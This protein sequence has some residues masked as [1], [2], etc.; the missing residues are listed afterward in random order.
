MLKK[1]LAVVIICLGLFF[2][3]QF[4]LPLNLQINLSVIA[5]SLFALLKF[6]LRWPVVIIYGLILDFFYG[7]LIVHL[8]S[9][10]LMVLVLDFLIS[11]LTILNLSARLFL[12]VGG[13]SLNLFFNY[14]IGLAMKVFWP[15]QFW[16]LIALDDLRLLSYLIFNSLII[17]LLFIIFKRQFK[18]KGY[19]IF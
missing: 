2:L 19:E 16:P 7:S 15:A 13:V 10:S 5:V 8:L 4:L 6:K 1:I 12:V 17:W 11:R 9:L 3:E 18:E 14:L